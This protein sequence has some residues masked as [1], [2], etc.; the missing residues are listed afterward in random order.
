MED[1]KPFGDIHSQSFSP[2]DL[3]KWSKWNSE[4]SS[5]EKK[6]GVIV[7]DKERNKD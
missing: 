1:K 6:Y 7:E 3:V 2:G 5:W 4:T